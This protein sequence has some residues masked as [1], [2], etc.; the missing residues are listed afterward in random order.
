MGRFETR[1]VGNATLIALQDS[2]TTLP[3]SGFF[4]TVEETAWEP[5]RDLLEDDGNMFLN[6]GAWMV[7]SEGRIILVDTGI[8]GRPV[9]MPLREDPTLPAVMEA[10]GVKPEEVDTVAFTH[11]HFD[12]TGWNTTD[13]G[14]T[15]KPLFGNARHV[16][17]QREWDHWTADD[18]GREATRYD[19][20]LAP[21]E[22]ANLLDLVEGEQEITSELIAIPT[23]G[24]TPGHMS[25]ILAS[26]GERAYLLGDAA[27]HPVQLSESTWSPNADIDPKQSAETRA[28][29][30]ERIERENALIASGHFEFPGLGHA[31]RD[32]GQLRFEP[33]EAGA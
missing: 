11:L 14:G 15:A 22:Q 17:Q 7:R 8:G 9:R 20:V 6:L 1:Q 13:E 10:A 23:P 4:G 25:F 27:H 3:P 2:W 24:H 26:G 29:L 31:R 18:A 32:G 33:L 30:F 5:Y 16:V 12:H 21:L 28:A 19:D